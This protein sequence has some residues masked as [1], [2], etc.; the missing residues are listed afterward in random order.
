M[1][2]LSS[3]SLLVKLFSGKSTLVQVMAWC[4]QATG[5]YLNQCCPKS[6]SPYGVSRPRWVKRCISQDKEKNSNQEIFLGCQLDE[7]YVLP[8]DHQQNAAMLCA[9]LVFTKCFL[10]LYHY[11][12]LQEIKLTTTISIMNE[13]SLK[14]TNASVRSMCPTALTNPARKPHTLHKSCRNKKDVRN[15]MMD[16]L[17]TGTEPGVGYYIRT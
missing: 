5:H 7:P 3:W 9:F 10:F 14:G 4:R 2:R 11:C 1:L 15:K 8:C 17:C 6:V 13:V 12:I 16:V